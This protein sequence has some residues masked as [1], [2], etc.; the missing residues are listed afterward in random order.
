MLRS[1]R[2]APLAGLGSVSPEDVAAPPL[3]LEQP[4][5]ELVGRAL[6]LERTLARRRAL[7]R[8]R[9]R[10]DAVREWLAA[11]AIGVVG[12]WLATTALVVVLGR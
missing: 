3:P 6:D 9:R 5:A 8:R 11:V 12:L 4:N 1:N 10:R 7:F 2:H